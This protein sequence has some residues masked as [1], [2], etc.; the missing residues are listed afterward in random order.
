MNKHDEKYIL[1]IIAKGNILGATS[2]IEALIMAGY[3]DPCIDANT[4][5][6]LRD[7]AHRE[8]AILMKKKKK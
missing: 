5:K 7:I 8:F 6:E 4:I 3:N 1:D 2:R